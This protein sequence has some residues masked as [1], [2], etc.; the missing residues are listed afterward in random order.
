MYLKKYDLTRISDKV[1]RELQNL[2]YGEME[3]VSTINVRSSKKAIWIV[4]DS[5]FTLVIYENGSMYLAETSTGEFTFIDNLSLVMEKLIE[6][7]WIDPK[8]KMPEI[9]QKIVIKFK[10]KDGFG[11]A[12]SIYESGVEGDH[13]G[14]YSWKQIS[15]YYTEIDLIGIA[16]E[17]IIGWLP[18]DN[19]VM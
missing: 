6:T 19:V 18:A 11:I 2:A 10:V 3:K 7:Q 15:I 1:A 12:S 9:G 16:I 14:E 5:E 17:D 13:T 4:G 8:M